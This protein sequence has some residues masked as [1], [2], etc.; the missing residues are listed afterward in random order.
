MKVGIEKLAVF[1]L[2]AIPEGKTDNK[3]LLEMI[4]SG[5]FDSYSGLNNKVQKLIFRPQK[6][7][8]IEKKNKQSPK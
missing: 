6:N 3:I 2:S 5:Y 7:T 8:F 4:R 1:S